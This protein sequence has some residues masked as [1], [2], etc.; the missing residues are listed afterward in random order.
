MDR[1]N[2]KEAA[3]TL[4]EI[5][6]IVAI[7]TLLVVAVISLLDPVEQI[8]RSRD[9]KRKQD[10]NV[11]QKKFEEWYNDKGCYPRLSEVAYTSSISG[12]A[13][14]ICST[15]DDSPNLTY[16]TDNI[17]CDPQ[18]P[19]HEYLYVTTGASTC[20]TAYVVYSRLAATYVRENDVYDCGPHGCGIAP[21]YGYDYLVSSPNAVISVSDDF[22]C[23]DRSSRCT[24]CGTYESCV[25]AM[26]DQVCITIYASKYLCCQ[27]EPGAGYCP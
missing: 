23:F 6:M 5:M 13:G 16:F 11:L 12:L 17:I 1:S 18:S 15:K 27:A 25:N 3:V 2:K 21:S 9:T 8:A 22:Y 20:P 26:Y 10:L 19:F 7:I 14:K 24:S 4:L